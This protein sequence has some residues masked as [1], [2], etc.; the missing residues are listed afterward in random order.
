MTNK[1][2]KQ[3]INGWL[4][5]DKPLGLSSAQAVGAVKRLLRPQKI[6]HGGTLDPLASGILPLALGEA[7]KTFQFAAANEKAYRF[8]VRWGEE[9]TTDDAEG[10][11]VQASEKRPAPAQIEAALPEFTGE[12]MQA[13]P[14]FSAIK[15][16]GKRAYAKARAGEAVSIP[17]RPVQVHAL[18]LLNC[19]DAEHAEFEMHCGKGTYVR[20]IAR[21]LGRKLN[22]LGYVS[23]L[24]RTK[25]GNFAQKDAISLENL[26]KLVHSAALD[27]LLLPV[28][29]V[30]DD[31]PAVELDPTA[32]HRLQNGNP[33]LLSP[34]D[35]T[36]FE[37]EPTTVQAL[38][39]R[40]LVAIGT[41]FAGELK[42]V[43]V[44]NL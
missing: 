30:L 27:E 18:R 40:K 20:A 14:D 9:R 10:E 7:T 38:Q 22:C 16:D 28:S 13:P 1:P 17:A 25:V 11:V 26:E 35:S 23:A 31:I 4:V 8:T 29:S 44:F 32:A 39:G 15:L 37:T 42:P 36:R 21:D 24:R 19:P 43:R 2:P 6:G 3:V 34:A 33:V 12:I 41:A 5:L